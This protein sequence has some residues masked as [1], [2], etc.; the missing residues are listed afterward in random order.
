MSARALCT[1][2]KFDISVVVFFFVRS[3]LWEHNEQGAGEKRGGHYQ[4]QMSDSF[5]TG[6]LA[7]AQA[8]TNER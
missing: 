8:A 3:V 2:F 7:R 5:R 6:E 4:M 1:K